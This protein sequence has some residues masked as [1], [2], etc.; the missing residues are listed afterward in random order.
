MTLHTHHGQGKIKILCVFHWSPSH[1][2]LASQTFAQERVM[3]LHIAQTT[4][5]HTH[6][7]G[8]VITKFI[9]FRNSFML[10]CTRH[11]K[12][13]ISYKQQF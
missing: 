1:P 3:R 11:N 2:S 4:T 6:T 5:P 9:D 13:N 8:P 12:Y 10:G 7:D